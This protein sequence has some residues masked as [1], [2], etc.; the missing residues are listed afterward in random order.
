MYLEDHVTRANLVVLYLF[1]WLIVSLHL[2]FLFLWGLVKPGQ[3]PPP[4]RATRGIEKSRGQ[5][6]VRETDGLALRVRVNSDAG[7]GLLVLSKSEAGVVALYP[8]T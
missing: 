8:T 1:S 7:D 5:G 2:V 4:A 3:A 6:E